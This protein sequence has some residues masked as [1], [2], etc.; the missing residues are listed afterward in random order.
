MTE[1]KY[2]LALSIVTANRPQQLFHSLKKIV[3]YLSKNEVAVYVFDGSSND[4]T[5]RLIS[6]LNCEDIFYEY[7]PPETTEIWKRFYDRKK[8]PNAEFVWTTS[9][10][11]IPN[12]KTI[13]SILDMLKKDIDL[14]V[15][16]TMDVQNREN[17]LYEDKYSFFHDN[18][19]H[20][21][22][23]GSIVFGRRII[24]EAWTKKRIEREMSLE[25]S[26]VEFRE[27]FCVLHKFETGKYLFTR[28]Y[29][30]AYIQPIV[31]KT[32]ATI[33]E[34]RMF[35]TFIDRVETCLKMLPKEYHL[36]FKHVMKSMNTKTHWFTIDGFCNLRYL[37]A[38]DTKQCFNYYN[39]L[40]KVSFVPPFIIILI[41][42]LPRELAGLIR[43]WIRKGREWK[44]KKY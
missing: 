40:K 39:K 5:G 3:N 32:S 1:Y 9:D 19:W 27:V 22:L 2:K 26:H 23:L 31:T 28:Y 29:A 13:E 14:V 41:S 36:H 4:K 20:M 12:I 43:D 8:V 24:N 42:L 34:N 44:N 6:S 35:I 30:N 16:N 17:L 11:R 7:Y 15:V 10:Q 18:C 25:G 21:Q 33:A 38:L 37:G